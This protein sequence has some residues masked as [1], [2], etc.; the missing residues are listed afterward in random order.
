MKNREIFQLDCNSN[1]LQQNFQYNNN[2]IQNLSNNSCMYVAS[3]LQNLT[4][5]QYFHLFVVHLM[6]FISPNILI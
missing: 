1:N 4:N 6:P 3:S 2:R 5:N